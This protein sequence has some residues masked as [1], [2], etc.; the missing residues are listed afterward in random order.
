MPPST[1]TYEMMKAFIGFEE[2]DVANLVKMAPVFVE[3]GPRITDL[4]YTRLALLPETAKQIEGRVDQLKKTHHRWMGELFAGEYGE[5]YF[6]N[7]L[8]IGMAHVRINL[9]PHWVDG[10]TSILRAEGAKALRATFGDID[11]Y[12]AMNR[13]L[14]RILDLDQLVINLAYADA[15]H[16]ERM[17]RLTKFTGMSRRLLDNCIRQA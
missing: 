8:R 11:E 14:V 6:Q 12:V 4:F 1:E 5:P 7:R 2:S 15:L 13:S 16:E 9:S 17:A 3:H 10:V